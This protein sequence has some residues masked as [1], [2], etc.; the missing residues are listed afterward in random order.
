MRRYQG[1]YP[2][3]PDTST[4]IA[5]QG[6][7]GD[8]FSRIHRPPSFH[9]LAKKEPNPNP[10]NLKEP[11]LTC[12]MRAAALSFPHSRGDR[13]AE[14]CPAS[15]PAAPSTAYTRGQTHST[16]KWWNEVRANQALN[17]MESWT[18]WLFHCL[19]V[20]PLVFSYQGDE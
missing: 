10:F 13:Q 16:S 11:P 19:I 6:V 3:F 7:V 9:T 18:L 14:P 8:L 20:C 1:W 4:D 17:A 12:R 2:R 15:T 5:E